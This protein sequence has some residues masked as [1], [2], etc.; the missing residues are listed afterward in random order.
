MRFDGFQRTYPILSELID[1]GSTMCQKLAGIASMNQWTSVQS[2]VALPIQEELLQVV[3]SL[4]SELDTLPREAAT[5]MQFSSFDEA[6][7]SERLIDGAI[8]YLD[9]LEQDL[10]LDWLNKIVASLCKIRLHWHE[11]QAQH[12]LC[13]DRRRLHQPMSSGATL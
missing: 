9:L 7:K 1:A 2:F 10:Q 13:V 3:N 6:T 8:H 4:Q 5:S 12:T 11:I